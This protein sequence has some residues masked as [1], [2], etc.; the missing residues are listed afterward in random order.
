MAFKKFQT[1]P[2]KPAEAEPCLRKVS[3]PFT[4]QHALRALQQSHKH[5]HSLQPAHSTSTSLNSIGFINSFRFF[6]LKLR[7]FL[8]STA[9]PH[10]STTR[11]LETAT[12]HI[13]GTRPPCLFWLPPWENVNRSTTLVHH[14]RVTSPHYYS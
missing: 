10:Q 14:M 13:K 9:R 3:L 11:P 7:G 8:Q 1:H 4:F 2:P 6:F 12:S 5:S